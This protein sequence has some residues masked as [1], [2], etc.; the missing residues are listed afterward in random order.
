MDNGH[1]S[2]NDKLNGNEFP[3][4]SNEEK[5]NSTL[6]RE[7]LLKMTGKELAKIAK[8]KS[9]FSLSTLNGFGKNRLVDIILGVEKEEDKKTVSEGRVPQAQSE[10]QDI[11][12]MGLSVLQAFKQQR[13]GEQALLNPIAHELFVSSAVA[14]VDEARADGVLK[15]D[16]FQTALLALSGTALVVDGVIGF[17]NIPGMLQKLK[18][19]L[20]GK[21]KE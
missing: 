4:D 11:V 13:E 1:D 9:K 10:S 19:K 12:T 5:G 6:T 14:K 17:D 15:T 16:K 21:P 3:F 20:T 2:G 7:E 18:S 8:P